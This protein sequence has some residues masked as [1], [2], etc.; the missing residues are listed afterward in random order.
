ME[1]LIALYAGIGRV[2]DGRGKLWLPFPTQLRNFLF[3]VVPGVALAY[4]LVGWSWW[5]FSALSQIRR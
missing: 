5:I 1:F 3:F 4:L 2:I